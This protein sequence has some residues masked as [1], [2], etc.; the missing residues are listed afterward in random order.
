[1]A[2]R[3]YNIPELRR[4]DMEHH[5]PAQA[6]YGEIVAL[7]GSRII[8]RAD[9]CTVWD[10]DGNALLDG[11]AGLWCVNVGYGREELAQAA[12][13][14]M[15]ELPFYNTFFKTATPPTVM[16]ATRLAELLGGDLQHVFFN[17]SGSE[18]NDTVMRMVRHYWHVHGQPTRTIFISRWNAYH[19]ST[20]AGA[21]LG[22]MKQMHPI[23]GLPIPGVEP[24]AQPYKFGEGFSADEDPFS[25]RSP[26]DI[27][28]PNRQF[29]PD[30]VACLLYQSP[31]PRD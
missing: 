3:N 20:M 11:M 27:A 30:N 28:D 16:L 4:L 8:T 7:G 5:L 23:G 2:G 31:S 6:N 25:A 9:G 21:S 26:Q 29:G 13:E 12:G 1:M 18:A 19:G 24:V 15:R 17:S 22:G 10:G 14:Q